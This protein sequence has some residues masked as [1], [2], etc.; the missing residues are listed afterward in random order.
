MT[1]GRSVRRLRVTR[2][3][4]TTIL[5]VVTVGVFAVTWLGGNPPWVVA[6]ATLAAA[7][8]ALLALRTR[9]AALGTLAFRVVAHLLLGLAALAVALLYAVLAVAEGEL[10][11]SLQSVVILA[12]LWGIGGAL[13]LAGILVA[14]SAGRP[15][16]WVARVG[17]SVTAVWGAYLTV[18]L[19]GLLVRVLT[20]GLDAGLAR[21]LGDDLV[22]FV[23]LFVSF[24]VL[25]VLVFRRD[26]REPGTP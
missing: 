15:L 3:W 12:S 4:A 22:P 26:V 5:A 16:R 21:S 7:G 18:V 25:P 24:V 1:P 20:T 17:L 13:V 19:A 8:L 23:V 2:P 9:G 10:T 11:G 14:A 6:V